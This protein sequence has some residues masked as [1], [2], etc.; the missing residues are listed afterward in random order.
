MKAAIAPLSYSITAAVE[1]TGLSK[2]HL[3]R[4]IRAGDLK[5]RKSGRDEETGEPV[6]KWVLLAKDLQAYLDSLP[7]G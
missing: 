2:S 3:D 6:G 7:E 5:A 1:A 4:A